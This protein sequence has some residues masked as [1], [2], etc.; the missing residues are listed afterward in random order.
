M[1]TWFVFFLQSWNTRKR[2]Q[3]AIFDLKK[4]QIFK[5]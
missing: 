4:N 5:R 3:D 1:F 2:L